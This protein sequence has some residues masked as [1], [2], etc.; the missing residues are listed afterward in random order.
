LKTTCVVFT[1]DAAAPE[2]SAG[3]VEAVA[4]GAEEVEVGTGV[5]EFEQPPSIASK[6]APTSLLDIGT[7]FKMNRT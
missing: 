6:H 5:T 1:P 3:D 4:V 2:S 7:P